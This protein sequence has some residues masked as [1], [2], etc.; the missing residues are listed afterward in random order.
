MLIRLTATVRP[1]SYED[2]VDTDWVADY[3][4]G[5]S[6]AVQLLTTLAA[7]ELAISIITFLHSSKRVERGSSN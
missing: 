4:K 7:D 6:P 5:K 1:L 2:L 3:L